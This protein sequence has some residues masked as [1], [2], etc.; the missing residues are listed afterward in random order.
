MWLLKLGFILICF[1]LFL[2]EPSRETLKIKLSGLPG[3]GQ[4]V[5]WRE[6]S[7]KRSLEEKDG[8]SVR[9]RDENS[10]WMYR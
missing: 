10:F 6:W 5:G 2:R 8:M 9:D 1:G 4:Q 3:K 7:L